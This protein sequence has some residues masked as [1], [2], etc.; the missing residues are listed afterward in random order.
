[1]ENKISFTPKHTPEPEKDLESIPEYLN[2]SPEK[3]SGL[4]PGM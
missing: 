2:F 3:K 4:G 1:M